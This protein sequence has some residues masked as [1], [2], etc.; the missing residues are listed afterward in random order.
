MSDP[1]KIRIQMIN[2]QETTKKFQRK[3]ENF[4]CQNCGKEVSGDGYTNHCPFCLWSKHV[5]DHPG[6]RKNLCKGMMEPVE[7]YFKK[8][9]WHLVHVCQKCG[10]RKTNRINERDDRAMLEEIIKNQIFY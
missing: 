4:V 8:G 6:D 3:K 2:K 1:G 9:Q 5:D 7:A 10:Q